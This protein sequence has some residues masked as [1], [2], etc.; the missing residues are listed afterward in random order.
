MEGVLA[1]TEGRA[2]VV[3][4][5]S[6]ATAITALKLMIPKPTL[7]K[8]SFVNAIWFPFQLQVIALLLVF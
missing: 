2:K 7:Q 8:K 3:D 4:F 1:F 6:Y 5:P